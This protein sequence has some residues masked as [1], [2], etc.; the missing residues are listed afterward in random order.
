MALAHARLLLEQAGLQERLAHLVGE[1]AVVAGEAARQVVERGVVAAPLAHAVEPLEDPARHT[2]HR[3]GVLVRARDRAGRLEQA[4]DLV[5]ERLDRLVVER[6]A[7]EARDRLG[8]S[9][10][11][12]GADRRAQVRPALQHV[13]GQQVRVRAQAVDAALV[14]L[15]VESLV[16]VLRRLHRLGRGIGEQQHSVELAEEQPQILTRARRTGRRTHHHLLHGRRG[17]RGRPLPHGAGVRA[18]LRCHWDRRQHLAVRGRHGH[19]DRRLVAG[20]A[21]AQLAHPARQLG[22]EQ[23]SQPCRGVARRVRAARVR[24][25]PLELAGSCSHPASLRAAA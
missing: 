1:R 24:E 2:P 16:R 17:E 19:R 6:R 15:R 13:A 11:V 10:R 25:R 5:L 3:V 21:V 9:Q 14:E 18:Q 8:H 4:Q 7:A 12:R 22:V 20:A 23:L